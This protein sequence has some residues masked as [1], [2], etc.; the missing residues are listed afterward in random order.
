MGGH[1][2]EILLA[3]AGIVLVFTFAF[4]RYIFEGMIYHLAVDLTDELGVHL[5]IAGWAMLLYGIF[6]MSREQK[7]EKTRR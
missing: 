6:C 5:Y 2:R 3:G 4:G 1:S 7:S